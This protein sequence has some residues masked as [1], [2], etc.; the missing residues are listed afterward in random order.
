MSYDREHVFDIALIGVDLDL[1]ADLP[2]RDEVLV[3]QSIDDEPGAHRVR[4]QEDCVAID[5]ALD[6]IVIHNVRFDGVEAN[7]GHYIQSKSFGDD[8]LGGG[9]SSEPAREHT[10]KPRGPEI[11][12]SRSDEPRVVRFVDAVVVNGDDM[13]NAE[14]CEVLVDERSDPPPE[15]NDADSLHGEDVLT[16]ISK[17]PDL[18]VVARVGTGRPL[19]FGI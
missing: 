9:W 5:E 13:A 17:E 6:R 7:V 16:T 11:P 3:A 19:R 12:W 2:D 14:A 18:A 4:R 1:G 8:D 10:R 15:T